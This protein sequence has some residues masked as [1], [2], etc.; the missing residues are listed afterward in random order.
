MQ[1]G[2]KNWEV[3]GNKGK[4]QSQLGFGASGDVSGGLWPGAPA[5]TWS[6]PD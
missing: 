6:V 3:E 1:P 4:P 5:R 2:L